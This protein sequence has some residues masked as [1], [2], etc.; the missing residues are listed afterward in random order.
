MKLRAG[1]D[2][3]PEAVR[4]HRS[5]QLPTTSPKEDARSSSVTGVE[6]NDTSTGNVLPDRDD[7]GVG[8]AARG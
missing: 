7:R 8:R 1:P 5:A 4:S 2:G 3:L 6:P